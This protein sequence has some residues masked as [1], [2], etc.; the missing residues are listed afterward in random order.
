[1]IQSQLWIA[2]ILR[3]D[4][5]QWWDKV[6]RNPHGNTTP[7]ES[8]TKRQIKTPINLKRKPEQEI[9]VYGEKDYE[10][11]ADYYGAGFWR[12]SYFLRKTGKHNTPCTPCR[13]TK[14]LTTHEFPEKWTDS[15][16]KNYRR[17]SS[18]TVYSVHNFLEERSKINGNMMI[19][20]SCYHLN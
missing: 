20:R 8:S 13:D 9:E 3:V 17:R 19:E 4:M 18:M 1:M 10:K 12:V 5:I 2:K 7:H 15:G 16:P 11:F 6:K 14:H